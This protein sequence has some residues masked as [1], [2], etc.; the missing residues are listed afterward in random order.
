MITRATA[1][2]IGAFVALTVVLV[3]YIGAQF[4]GLFAFIGPRDYTVK[5]PLADA[6]GLFER[7]E[8]TFRGVKVGAVGPLQLTDD[9]VVADLVIDGSAPKIPKD[10]N[11]VVADRSAVG[12][13]YVD[14]RPNADAAPYLED[15]SAIAADRVSTPVPVQDVLEN[16][17]KLA[18][19]VPLNDL[20]TVVGELGVAFDGLGPKLGLLLDSTNSL[21]Q[22]ANQYLPQTLALIHDARTVLRTQNDLADPIKSFSSDLRKV[23]QQLKDSDKDIRRIVDDGPDAA[24]ELSALIDESGPG[25]SDTIREALTTSRIT[26][27]HLWSLRSILIAYPILVSYIPTIVPGDG[28]AHL[29]LVLNV[30]DPPPCTKGYE[31]T[32]KRPGTDISP[33]PTNYRAFCREPLYSPID[34]RGVKPQYP[35]ENG[36]PG[37]VPDWFRKFYSDGPRAGIDPLPG[38]HGRGGHGGADPASGPA[39]PG[40]PALPGLLDAPPSDGHFG[41]TPSLLPGG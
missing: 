17:D 38:Q 36:R 22:T 21:T 11:A 30:N 10:L 12:E 34:V 19:N 31:A 14:L 28:T 13:R 37:P 25:L 27:E 4:L 24:R 40:Q 32:H 2:R 3:V 8:V 29:G 16:L 15:G 18:A 23:T 9:G 20:R 1:I 5:M 35:F 6:S 41:L 26:K 39:L 33:Q 7:A